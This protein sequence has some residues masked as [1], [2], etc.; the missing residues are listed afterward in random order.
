[1]AE[2]ALNSALE[3]SVWLKSYFAEYVRASG[4]KPY[5]GRGDGSIIVAK[6]EL[7]EEAGKT[8][9]IPL[10]TRLTSAGVTGSG[11]IVVTAIQAQ[12]ASV[13]CVSQ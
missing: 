2:V 10:I 3:K 11:F 1:M 13:A 6:Y 9:N 8:I 5:M 4:F 12:A 7:Q